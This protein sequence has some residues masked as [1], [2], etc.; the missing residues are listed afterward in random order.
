MYPS[1]FDELEKISADVAAKKK[2]EKSSKLMRGVVNARPWV[3]SAA[4]GALPAASLAALLPVN[5]DISKARTGKA[6]EAIKL[7]AQKRKSKMIAVVGGLG[8]AAGLSDRY[9]KDWAAKHPKSDVSKKLHGQ[10][11]AEKGEFKKTSA[12][13]GDLR[14]KGL[15][16]VKEPPFPTED[17]KQKAEQQLNSSHKPGHF[18][19]QSAPKNLTRPGPSIHQT[20]TLPR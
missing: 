15:G 13:A 6:I 14:K 2:D 8:A 18:G 7:H 5:P 9:M 11:Q 12:M 19:T 16:G 10:M 20:A 17:S 4:K 1:F 3:T